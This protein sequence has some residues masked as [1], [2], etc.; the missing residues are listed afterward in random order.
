MVIV[1]TFTS[2][3]YNDGAEAGSHKQKSIRKAVFISFV[4]MKQVVDFRSRM[5][6]FRG[7]G[8]EAPLL[9][10]RESHLPANPA[11]VSYITLQSTRFNNVIA[12]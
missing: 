6:A 3:S 10:L 8:G 7:A 11:G 9:R 1:N 5:L 12:S 2:L 4:A